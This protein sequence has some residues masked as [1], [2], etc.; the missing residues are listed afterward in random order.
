MAR[1]TVQLPN[2]LAPIADADRIPLEA[3]T[4]GGALQTL[5]ELHPA[6]RAHLFDESGSLRRHVLCF[7]N[8]KNTRWLDSL[9]VAVADDDTIRILQAVSGG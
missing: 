3:N 6:L 2:L 1:I 5:V 8:E 4:V 7:H 9:E